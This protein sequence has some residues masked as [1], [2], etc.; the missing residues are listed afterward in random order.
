MLAGECDISVIVTAHHEGRLAHR[1]MRS[2]SRAVN[3]ALSKG[4]RAETIVVMDSPDRRTEEYFSSVDDAMVTVKGVKFG[5]LGLSRNFGVG[6]ASGGYIAILDADDLMGISWLHDGYTYLRDKSSDLIVHPEY[7][8]YFGAKNMIFRQQSST[9]G[10][11]LI[12]LMENNCWAS[13]CAAKKS[14]LLKYPYETTTWGSGF[15]YE[16]WHWNCETLA[17]GIEHHVVPG[18]VCFVRSKRTASL[19]LTSNQQHRIMRPTGL[20]DPERFGPIVANDRR[21]MAGLWSDDGIKRLPKRLHQLSRVLRRLYRFARSAPAAILRSL[22]G[23]YQTAKALRNR[24]FLVKGL[25]KWLMDEWTELHAIDPDVFPDRSVLDTIDRYQVPRALTAP[26]FVAL[27]RQYGDDVSHVF[28]VPWLKRGGADLETL[29]YIDALSRHGLAHAVVVMATE[30]TDSPWA[31]RLPPNVRF[32]QFRALCGRLQ[33]ED[34]ERLLARVL[35]QMAPRVVHNINSDLG[36]RVFVKYGSALRQ[37]SNLYANVFCQDVTDE[38]QSV[39]YA[40]S[41]LPDCFDHVTAVGS[42]N[43]T[44]LNDLQRLYAFDPEKCFVHYQPMASGRRPDARHRASRTDGLDVLWAGRMDR[45]KRPDILERI[46]AA[47][48]DLPVKFHV[49]GTPL[50]D[51]NVSLRR[52]KTLKNVAYHGPFDGFPSL[53][54]DR[55]DLYLYTSQWDGLPNV[56]LEAIAAGLPIVASHVGGVGELIAD[57]KTG[58]LIEPYDDV[59]AYVE[60][61]TRIQR[62]RSQ[63]SGVINNAYGV[64][65]ARHSWLRFIEDLERFPGYI[66]HRS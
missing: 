29:N 47:C 49:Y 7:N 54:T 23:L 53:Q 66:G 44:F 4:V 55:F 52:L 6:Q 10:R 25:P 37:V 36:Y 27:C 64:L 24:L 46:A 45:Q 38:G 59:Q 16:D 32:L 57:G 1:T 63:L 35:L 26:S 65:E 3:Y 9:D 12:D 58:F 60:C 31:S 2:V 22:P 14:L 18:T 28:L 20:F 48:L 50:L 15:G 30:D 43:Q 34:Q 42:D 11:V 41:Y 21:R 40:L 17:G 8:I 5:D 51:R 39:G 13:I 19:L 33:A 56:L 62:D 61:L